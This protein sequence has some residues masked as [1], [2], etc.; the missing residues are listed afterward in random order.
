MNR[1]TV[2]IICLASLKSAI[3]SGRG[4]G[5]KNPSRSQICFKLKRSHCIGKKIFSLPMSCG[6]GGKKGSSA[7]VISN[8]KPAAAAVRLRWLSRP[9][10]AACSCLLSS[11][12]SHFWLLT[13]HIQ[14][15]CF[16]MGYLPSRG[17]S[18]PPCMSWCGH[19]MHGD[20]SNVTCKGINN[21][22]CVRPVYLHV[23]LL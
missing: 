10:S 1:A 6:G 13:L 19:K 15:E 17:L 12:D 7:A 23:Y 5:K 9:A 8:S 20:G 21:L 18:M 14:R 3:H 2:K 11:G 4:L 16:S 22:Y